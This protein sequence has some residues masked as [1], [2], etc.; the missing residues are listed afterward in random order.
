MHVFDVLS[1]TIHVSILSEKIY[2]GNAVFK[3]FEEITS[4]W[5]L[6]DLEEILIKS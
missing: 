4:S 3:L 1:T 5:S 2:S 6:I